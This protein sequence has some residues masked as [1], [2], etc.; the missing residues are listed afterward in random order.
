MPATTIDVQDAQTQLQRLVTLALKGGDVVIAKDN[1]PLVRLVPVQ[2]QTKARMASLHKGAMQ[3]SD[4]FNK[5]L[6]DDFW[7]GAA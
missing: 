3:M 1:V 2:A 7:L 4:D 6:P 5:P